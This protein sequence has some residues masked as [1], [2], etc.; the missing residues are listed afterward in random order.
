M[1]LT[2]NQVFAADAAL[3]WLQDQPFGASTA[4]KVARIRATLTNE[5]KLAH[6]QRL[7]IGNRHGK[8]NPQT[9]QFEFE[10]PENQMEFFKELKE[11]GEIEITVHIDPLP[12]QAIEHVQIT[13]AHIA[14]LEP[15]LLIEDAAAAE[16]EILANKKKVG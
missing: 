14:G 6:D 5:V 9:N 10:T 13:P 7:T 16:P 3:T 4:L 15:L 2:I 8:P 11:F 12:L 1:K